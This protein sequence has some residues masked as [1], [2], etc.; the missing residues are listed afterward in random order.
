MT[1]LKYKYKISVGAVFKQ[2]AHALEE[3]IN[4]YLNHG[5]EHIYLI[6]DFST[7]NYK[8]IIEK[9]K[10][11]VTLYDSDIITNK[12]GK[13]LIIYDKYFRPILHE[14]EYLIIADL[15]EFLY[16]PTSID[17]KKKLAKFAQYSQIMVKWL[18]FGSNNHIK[19]PPSIIKGFVKRAKY[20]NNFEKY[21]FKSIIKTKDLIRFDI[22]K[23]K[24]NGETIALKVDSPDFI[25]NHY[26][27]QS[28]NFW[29]T[30]KCMEEV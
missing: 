5:V 18:K 3:W 21:V 2:E 25:I 30:V 12:H 7:D 10:N 1:E 29:M 6:N 17:I 4:H 27:C 9:Y 26:V 23:H 19:Q 15:D 16:S 14:T 8:Q 22:H 11:N 13:Q 20:D 24:C 28:Y